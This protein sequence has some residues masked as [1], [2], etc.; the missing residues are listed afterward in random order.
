MPKAFAFST[1]LGSVERVATVAGVLL[2][3]FLAGFVAFA[4]S[5]PTKEPVV[6]RSADG[7][8]ALTGGKERIAK[9]IRLLS[10]SQGR[11]LLISGVHPQTSRQTLRRSAPFAKRLFDCCIDIGYEAR[12]TIGNARETSV[13]SSAFGFRRLLVVTSAYHMPRS[14]TELRR[15]MPNVELVPHPIIPANVHIRNWWAYPGTTRL[16]FTEYIKYLTANV[17]LAFARLTHAGAHTRDPA[18]EMRA[19]QRAGS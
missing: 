15:T 13:W 4:F 7:I 18:V 14:I 9:A 3:V 1:R 10:Q 2:I 11:R 19:I 16:L 6:T 12:N 5:I 8:V 17:R